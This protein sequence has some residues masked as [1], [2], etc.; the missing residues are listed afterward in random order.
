LN[1]PEARNA[2][3]D[4]LSPAFRQLLPTL[5][6]DP[7][8]RC[9]LVTG[10]GKA[11]C[12][13]GDVKGMT[14]AG[15]SDERAPTP[16]RQE[17]VDDLRDR[18]IALTG[19][20]YA[21]P[22]PTLAALPGPAAGAGL[23]IALACD[24]RIAARSAFITTAFANI[25]LSGDYGSSFFMT[26]LVGTARARELFFGADRVDAS[27]CEELGLVNRVVDD[28]RLRMEAFE[29]ARSLAS[30]PTR[31]FAIMKENLDRALRSDLH[32]CLT[33]EAAGLI[34]CATTRDH[35]AAVQAFIKKEKPVFTGS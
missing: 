11:F 27:R 13:G 19:A 3:S 32:T 18:Q 21:F 28:D 15:R 25:G 1:R 33:Y 26:Q 14:P 16:T 23:S 12:A 5:A 29:W 20:L 7:E 31:A 17:R 4:R 9:L 10:A 8:V 24:L 2:L 22:K 35:R 6:K 34:E 30:G